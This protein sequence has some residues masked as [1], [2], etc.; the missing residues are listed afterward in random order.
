[1]KDQRKTLKLTFLGAQLLTV[2][3]LPHTHTQKMSFI[4]LNLS[5]PVKDPSCVL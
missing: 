2:N 1:M 5:D 4:Y 3:D